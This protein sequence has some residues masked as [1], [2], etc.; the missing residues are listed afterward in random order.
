M[1]MASVGS[2]TVKFYGGSSVTMAG[3]TFLS[4][5]DGAPITLTSS[6]TSQ[7][8]LTK[9]STGYVSSNWLS[10]DY[11]TVGPEATSWYAGANSIDG[12]HNGTPT[13]TFAA[14]ATGLPMA[15]FS[16]QFYQ[17]APGPEVY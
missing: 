9:S 5:T 13:W 4:G 12:G 11:C 14:P 1:S 2:L 8:T 17:Y 7:F 3:D 10:I 16:R 6:T 15:E